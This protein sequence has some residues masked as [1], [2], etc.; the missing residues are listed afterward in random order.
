MCITVWCENVHLCIHIQYIHNF[1]SVCSHLLTIHTT[2]CLR[3]AVS[4]RCFSSFPSSFF[5]CLSKQ[6]LEAEKRD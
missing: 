5:Y 4:T 2:E 3:I 6:F 1:L